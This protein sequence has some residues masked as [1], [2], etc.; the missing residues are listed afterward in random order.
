MTIT[1]IISAIGN[2]NSIYPLLLRD[3][4]IEVPVKVGLTYKQN[5]DDKNIAYLAT[6]ERLVDEYTTSAVWLGGI[7]LLGKCNSLLFKAKGFNPNVNSKLL[8]ENTSQGLEVNIKKF[9]DIAKNEVKDLVKI[10]NNLGKYR[11]L[12]VVKALS[13]TL[14]PVALMGFVIP[15][16]IFS[17]TSKTKKEIAAKQKLKTFRPNNSFAK[18]CKRNIS[19]GNN[20]ATNIANMTT[21][22]KMALTDGGYAVGR[23]ATARNKDA[24]IDI[25]FKMLGMMFLNF[26]F[27]KQLAKTLDKLT[28]AGINTNLS[29]DIRLLAD[30]EFIKEIKE[31][32]IEL[33]K[34]NKSQE[35]LD[36]ID[37]NPKSTFLKYAQKYGGLKML[38][39]GIRDPREYVDTSSLKGFM[40]SMS[41]IVKN[42]QKSNNVD[43]YMKKAKFLK[44]TNILLNV[45][46]TSF[47][48]AYA[49]PKAQF[50]FRKKILKQTYEPGIANDKN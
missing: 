36:Y 19:F 50:L 23:I 37:K 35:I 12:L 31:N 34:I 25:G 17:W 10:K 3:C 26:V 20:I 47:L 48:L 42:A 11:S 2:N 8:K 14:I 13:E 6:R 32:K 1:K 49:L 28:G 43:G 46:I 44:G 33:P 7:P 9:K 18:F 30:K 27:P 39:N 22:Q 41:G 4:G 45:G 5:K 24:A 29:C 21:V 40:E 38:N 15:K 16:L